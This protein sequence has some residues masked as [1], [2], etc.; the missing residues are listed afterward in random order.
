MAIL[1]HNLQMFFFE[2]IQISK[3]IHIFLPWFW[4]IFQETARSILNQTPL[5]F[6]GFH[7]LS[8]GTLNNLET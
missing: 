4:N 3:N 5:L 8:L 1:G 6:H 2:K 7:H